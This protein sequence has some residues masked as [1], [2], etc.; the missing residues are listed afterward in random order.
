MTEVKLYRYPVFGLICTDFTVM[1]IIILTYKSNLMS[2]LPEIPLTYIVVL[3]T[4]KERGVNNYIL[5][6]SFFCCSWPILTFLSSS[7]KC[8]ALAFLLHN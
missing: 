6:R 2:S 8:V 1:I 3:L 5:S 4:K 7:V